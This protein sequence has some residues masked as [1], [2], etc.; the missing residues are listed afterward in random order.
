M[1][2]YIL[3]RFLLMIPVLLGVAIVIFTILY[4]TPGDPAQIILGSTAS[5]EEV[6]KLRET[7]GLNDPYIVRLGRF[8][9]DTFLHFD[10]GT[11]YS[12]GI[13]VMTSLLERLPRTLWLALGGMV[14]ATLI[15][16][17]LGIIAA[18]YQDSWID[19]TSV[20]TALFGVS[21]PNF[22]LALLLI[23]LF[24][25]KLGWLPSFGIDDGIKSYI[26]PWIATCFQL[27]AILARQSRS[28]MLEV[29]RA[30]YIM[31]ARAKGATK[32]SEIFKHALPN[33]MIPIITVIGGRLAGAFGGSLII[34][35]L[36]SIPGIGQYVIKGVNNRDYAA[37]QGS[38]IFTSVM[39]GIIMLLVDIVYAF[40]DPRIKEQ[41]KG[42]KKRRAGA[43]G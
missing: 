29:I 24:S 26:L 41:Y 17:P 4:F 23:I 18:V 40:V 14:I 43:D 32:K 42:A 6:E 28:S 15:G 35:N 16:V 3:K 19:R 33:A 34:E 20:F 39:F 38:V 22:W 1:V 30:D 13:P 5:A 11:S 21:M 27:M 8:L 31:T 2:K 36:F 37:V 9:K 12:T 7:M 10:L 25:V